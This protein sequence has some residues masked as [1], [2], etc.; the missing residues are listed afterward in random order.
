M[1]EDAPYI[2]RKR[3]LLKEVA[4]VA[5]ISLDDGFKKFATASALGISTILAKFDLGDI[6][7]D[8]STEFLE[9]LE[10][11]LAKDGEYDGEAMYFKFVKL[12]CLIH[13]TISA[14]RDFV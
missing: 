6:V 4:I 9:E 1:S 11:E 5:A 12:I 2:S 10:E 8:R 3:K 14:V 7:D 13:E